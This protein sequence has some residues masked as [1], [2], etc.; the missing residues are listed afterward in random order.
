M[1]AGKGRLIAHLD[2][3]PASQAK[4]PPNKGVPAPKGV[5]V[6][7]EWFQPNIESAPEKRIR[8]VDHDD[9]GRT[10]FTGTHAQWQRLKKA[11][12]KPSPGPKTKKGKA[13]A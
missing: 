7:E 8:V 11:A 5:L 4:A 13:G 2:V 12:V 3:V 9:G 1:T 6:I 10:L